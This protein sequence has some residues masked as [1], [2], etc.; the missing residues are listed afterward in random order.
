MK[1]NHIV[2]V[3]KTQYHL[4]LTSYIFPMQP[5]RTSV[6]VFVP[7]MVSISVEELW[8]TLSG[9]WLLPT[10]WRGQGHTHTHILN[11]VMAQHVDNW[12]VCVCVLINATYRRSKRP[13]AYR[14]LLGVHTERAT[15]LS[16][17][18]KRLE[19]LVLGPNRADIALLKLERWELIIPSV[20]N[21][22]NTNTLMM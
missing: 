11:P 14:V 4:I 19:K 18:D 10:A 5:E 2:I 3:K 13:S 7:V 22:S 20:V 1:Q 16:K 15:E 9:S 12:C 21:K 17:Q 8:S 6:C